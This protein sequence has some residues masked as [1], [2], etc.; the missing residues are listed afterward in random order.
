[1]RIGLR[2][3]RPSAGVWGKGYRPSKTFS[4]G[5]H[6]RNTKVFCAC[7]VGR[8]NGAVN[9]KESARMTWAVGLSGGFEGL[10]VSGLY[11]P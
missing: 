10:N 8:E 6:R 7:K 2:P 3:R 4:C 9:R 5:C 1:M 11:I